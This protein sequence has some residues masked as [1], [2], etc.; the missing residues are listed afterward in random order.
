[1][2]KLT[3]FG[4]M[5]ARI[6]EKNICLDNM[7]SRISLSEFLHRFSEKHEHR[8]KDLLFNEHNEIKDYLFITVNDE[9][10]DRK[11]AVYL[12]DGDEVAILSPIAGGE[13]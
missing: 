1:M 13:R 4:H 3:L 7:P 9:P 12:S 10:V 6:G 8:C 11:E 2:I 5:Q